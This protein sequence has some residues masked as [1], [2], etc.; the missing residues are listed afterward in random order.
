MFSGSE[1]TRNGAL[2]CPWTTHGQ[3]KQAYELISACMLALA[4]LSALERG[5][6]QTRDESRVYGNEK[7]VSTPP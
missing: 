2:L 1:H 4:W 5:L 7:T 6:S 3:A